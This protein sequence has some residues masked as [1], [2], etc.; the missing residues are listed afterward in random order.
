MIGRGAFSEVHVGEDKNTLRK[1]AIKLLIRDINEYQQQKLLLRELS[2]LSI[3]HHPAIVEFIGFHLP[4]HDSDKAWIVSEYL[5]NK[6]LQHYENISQTRNDTSYNDTIKTIIAYGI[7]SGMAYIHAHRIVH[8]DLKPENIFLDKN[9]YPK[10]ADFGL[11]KSFNDE[12]QMTSNL[13]TPV[14]MAPELFDN[15]EAISLKIDVY[16]YGILLISMFT[17]GELKFKLGQPKNLQQFCRF[18]ADGKRF[19]YPD[20]VPEPYKYIIEMCIKA[21]PDERPFFDEIVNMLKNESCVFSDDVDRNK[22]KQYIEELDKYNYTSQED[23]PEK[24]LIETP[25]YN[26]DQEVL[27]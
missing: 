2:T 6:T 15:G 17:N 5:E 3:L 18:I 27:I 7:A 23:N 10:I 4:K 1:V 9:Y 12:I 26:F 24:S 11:A 19:K 13:G 21:N 8:R 14:Y 20:T 16:S 25:I 22:I